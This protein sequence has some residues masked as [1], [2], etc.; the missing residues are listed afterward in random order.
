MILNPTNGMLP[1]LLQVIS[2]LRVS[3]YFPPG[4]LDDPYSPSPVGKFKEFQIILLVCNVCS[5]LIKK[6]NIPIIFKPKEKK[7]FIYTFQILT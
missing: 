6:F 5:L 4:S 1:L 3:L 2:I 7:E